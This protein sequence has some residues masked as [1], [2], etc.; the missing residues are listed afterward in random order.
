MEWQLITFCQ[1]LEAA[2]ADVAYCKC[3]LTANQLD[4]Q[5][6]FTFASDFSQARVIAAN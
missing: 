1:N 2:G 3:R 6:R 5:S 4:S